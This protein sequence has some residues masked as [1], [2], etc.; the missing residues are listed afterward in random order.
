MQT[1][2]LIALHSEKELGDLQIGVGEGELQQ[3]SQLS[4]GGRDGAREL[5]EPEKQF[6]QSA[7]PIEAFGDATMQVIRVQMKYFQLDTIGELR[8]NG[9]CEIVEWRR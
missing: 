5:V 9:A 7:E 6:L 1:Q 3:T 2:E 4:D 8:G